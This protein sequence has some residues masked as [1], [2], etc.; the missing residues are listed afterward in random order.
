[1]DHS[2]RAKA[3]IMSDAYGEKFLSGQVG[4]KAAGKEYVKKALEKGYIT[5]EEARMEGLSEKDIEK[6]LNEQAK[7]MD[8]R[9]REVSTE[10]LEE[11][12][13]ERAML[14]AEIEDDTVS[15]DTKAI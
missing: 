11:I 5:E 7:T 2:E 12:E 1:V 8:E 15:D 10:E 9:M 3:Y 6:A 13:I 4:S 14:E